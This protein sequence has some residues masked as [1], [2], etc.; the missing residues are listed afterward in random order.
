MPFAKGFGIWELLIILAIIMII[1][2]VGRL[3]EIGGYLG[4]GIREF[5]KGQNTDQ[6]DEQ[7]SEAKAEAAQEKQAQP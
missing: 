1:F 4:K 7:V 6:P 5:K 2:G 3:P